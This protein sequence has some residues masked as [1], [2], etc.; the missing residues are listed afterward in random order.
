[1]FFSFRS[2]LSEV[3]MIIGITGKSCAG[4]NV[5]SQH[6]SRRG[7]EVWDLDRE[8]EK[9]RKEKRREVMNVFGTTDKAEL[10]KIVFSDPAKL[11]ELENIIY[12]ELVKKIK[13]CKYD[14]VINGATLKRANLDELCSF[15]IYVDASYETRL[16]RAIERD[17]VTEAE[18]AKRDAAQND[19]DF[20]IN[21]YSC[22]VVYLSTEKDFTG[23]LNEILTQMTQ[24][25]S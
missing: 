21:A 13:A 14:L 18:F 10:A 15:I 23:N 5:V 3:A 11:K 4:K 8:A 6:L 9:I 25:N 12:P 16:K 17:K 19:T 1:M 7:F 24:N 22:K 20:R 2:L